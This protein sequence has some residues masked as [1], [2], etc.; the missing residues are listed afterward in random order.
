MYSSAL[1]IYSVRCVVSSALQL[2][3]EIISRFKKSFFFFYHNFIKKIRSLSGAM[4]LAYNNTVEKPDP[5]HRE[6]KRNINK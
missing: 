4:L 6:R 2:F 5:N 1:R 3:N